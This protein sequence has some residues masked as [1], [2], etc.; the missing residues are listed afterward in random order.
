MTRDEDKCSG[1]SWERK[2]VKV[3]EGRNVD[4]KSRG[5]NGRG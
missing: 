3:E 1:M 5:V 2:V 4:G